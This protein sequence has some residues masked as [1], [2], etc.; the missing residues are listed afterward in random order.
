MS[1]QKQISISYKSDDFLKWHYFL[2]QKNIRE[3]NKIHRSKATNDSFLRK[4]FERKY[5]KAL[6]TSFLHPSRRYTP[7]MHPLEVPKAWNKK[8]YKI[9]AVSYVNEIA[10]P[11]SS[12]ASVWRTMIMVVAFEC[13]FCFSFIPW[14]SWENVFVFLGLFSC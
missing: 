5:T 6:H 7:A 8:R 1:L 4:H 9:W 11:A 14:K 10:F 13:K 12:S 2:H 3:N